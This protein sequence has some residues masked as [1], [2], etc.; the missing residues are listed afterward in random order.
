VSNHIPKEASGES[1]QD[2][3]KKKKKKEF[4]GREIRANGLFKKIGI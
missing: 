1:R 2:K 3:K 4:H